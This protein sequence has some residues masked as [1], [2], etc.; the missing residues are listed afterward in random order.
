MKCSFLDEDGLHAGVFVGCPLRECRGMRGMC[1]QELCEELRL[2]VAGAC[3]VKLAPCE[4]APLFDS[5]ESTAAYSHL[6]SDMVKPC[7]AT[8]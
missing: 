8:L 1:P 4:G 6:Q 5:L 7:E 3:F 2:S